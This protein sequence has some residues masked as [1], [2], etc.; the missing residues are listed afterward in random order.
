MLFYLVAKKTDWDS[1]QC[2]V[3]AILTHGDNGWVYGT[4]T[5]CIN[6]DYQSKVA[7]KQILLQFNAKNCPKLSGKPKIFIIQ[8]F[9]ESFNKVK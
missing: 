3:F 1:Y 2:L 8:V 4:D 7:I 9:N 6:G 5:K